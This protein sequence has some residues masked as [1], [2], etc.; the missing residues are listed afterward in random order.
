MR[1]HTIHNQKPLKTM[2]TT[3]HTPGPFPLE[4]TKSD[5]HFVIVTNHGSH[6]AKTFDPYAAKLIAATPDLL[7][8]LQSSADWLDELCGLIQSGM[9]DAASDWVGANAVSTDSTLRAAI[10]K[11]KGGE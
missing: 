10:F 5:D 7:S 4:I 8:A 11:A 3:T 2:K 1:T 6:F 9:F